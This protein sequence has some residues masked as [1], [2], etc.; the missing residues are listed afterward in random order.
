MNSGPFVVLH[1]KASGAIVVYSRH[2]T[3]REAE[4]VI[5]QLAQIGCAARVERARL[6]DVPG[7]QRRTPA[8][9]R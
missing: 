8:H 4:L 9:A 6:V 5:T 1:T 3:E 7:L 2:D